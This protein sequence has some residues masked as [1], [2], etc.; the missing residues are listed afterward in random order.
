MC[1]RSGRQPLP[2]AAVVIGDECRRLRKMSKRDGNLRFRRG[3]KRGREGI[4]NRRRRMVHRHAPP[5]VCASSAARIEK[6]MR[7]A[8]GAEYA[9]RRFRRRKR[10]LGQGDGR[11][12]VA[13][14]A[15]GAAVA[16][17]PK[18][19]LFAEVDQD[20]MQAVAAQQFGN[21]VGDI[22]L[23]KPVQ[24]YPLIVAKAD[25]GGRERNPAPVHEASRWRQ[26]LLGRF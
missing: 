26:P 4:G 10:A 15:P 14:D 2:L 18:R 7:R 25:R 9:A 12:I 19:A 20:M 22:A 1:C 23:A 24:G 21:A 11:C 16:L 13:G 3:I 8:G 17:R 5:E 6:M